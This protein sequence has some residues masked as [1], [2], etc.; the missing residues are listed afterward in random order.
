MTGA[1]PL[2]V[3]MHGG[4]GNG[5]QAERAYHWNDKADQQHFLVAYPDGLHRAQGSGV[6]D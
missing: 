2:V 6:V 3:M 1:V 5:A 4:F